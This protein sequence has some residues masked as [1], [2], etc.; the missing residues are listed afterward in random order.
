MGA[1]GTEVDLSFVPG[2]IKDGSYRDPVFFLTPPERVDDNIRKAILD[3]GMELTA[4]GAIPCSVMLDKDRQALNLPYSS[5]AVQG[6]SF[7]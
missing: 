5:H 6:V 1:G 2:S 3:Y 7:I 4:Q